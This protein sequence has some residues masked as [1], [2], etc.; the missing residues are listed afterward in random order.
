MWWFN[1][2]VR[3]EA[4][5]LISINN[6]SFSDLHMLLYVPWGDSSQLCSVLHWWQ[7]MVTQA[8]RELARMSLDAGNSS[9]YRSLLIRKRSDRCWVEYS[10]ET[11]H[12]D[13]L[14]ELQW[15]YNISTVLLGRRWRRHRPNNNAV[16]F[17]Y[18][19]VNDAT[20]HIHGVTAKKKWNL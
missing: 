18:T 9:V 15:P 2:P 19:S 1:N 13:T 12:K 14:Y 11:T 6:V 17:I 20:E 8:V 4:K 5:C 7:T 10:G 3:F 16:L